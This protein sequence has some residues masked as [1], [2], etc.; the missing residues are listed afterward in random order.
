VQS[1]TNLNGN[2][3]PGGNKKKG[4]ITVR[5]GRMVINPRTIIIMIRWVVMLERENEKDVR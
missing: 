2:Q 4:L 1:S 3:K 5:V